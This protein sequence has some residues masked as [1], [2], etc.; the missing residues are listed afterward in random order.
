LIWQFS[1]PVVWSLLFALPL[2]YFASNAYLN[3]FAERI[4]A[5]AGIVAGAGLLAI[6][7]AWCIVAIHAIRIARSNPIKALRYE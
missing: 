4:S 6:V 1:K 7:F 5:P 3:F 2:A